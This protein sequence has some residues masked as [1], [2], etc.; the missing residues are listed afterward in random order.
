MTVKT[1]FSPPACE[2]FFVLDQLIALLDQSGAKTWSSD[3][4]TGSRVAPTLLVC[5]NRQLVSGQGPPKTIMTAIYENK[6]KT[7]VVELVL[8]DPP[9][10]KQQIFTTDVKLMNW[11][12]RSRHV[13][14]ACKARRVAV[15]RHSCSY[16]A[17]K[18]ETYTLTERCDSTGA[19]VPVEKLQT[20]TSTSLVWPKVGKSVSLEPVFLVKT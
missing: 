14:M 8:T 18:L 1:S 19:L 20:S 4:R 3:W 6:K 11:G 13:L 10:Y 9:E 7:E 2:R 5:N 15:V 17:G 12:P 16:S